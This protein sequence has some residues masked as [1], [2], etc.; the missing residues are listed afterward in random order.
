MQGHFL[1]IF[2]R[3]KKKKINTLR[4]WIVGILLLLILSAGIY[5]YRLIFKPFS[6]SETV[7]IYID[8][9]KNYEEVVLQLQEKADFLPKNISSVSGVD[10]LPEQS[11]NGTVCY[12]RRY[13]NARCLTPFAF[14]KPN[15]GQSHFQQHSHRGESCGAHLTTGL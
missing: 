11:E 14:R 6:L 9:Q 4:L 8:E 5:A 2:Q 13:D 1:R 15:T 7:Y 12:Q 3:K 10:E